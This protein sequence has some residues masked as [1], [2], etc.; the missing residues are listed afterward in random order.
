[1]GDDDV[2]NCCHGDLLF[3]ITSDG[4]GVSRTGSKGEKKGWKGEERNPVKEKD[5]FYIRGRRRKERR[6]PRM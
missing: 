6:G 3:E 2:T 5:H 1:M 4:K